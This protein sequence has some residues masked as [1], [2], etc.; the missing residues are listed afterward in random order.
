MATAALVSV[1]EYLSTVYEPEC[2][3]VDGVLEERNVGEQDHG[4]LTG[5]FMVLLYP[6]ERKLGVRAI[7]EVRL[8][9][10]PSRFRVPDLSVVVGPKRAEQVFT[11]APFLCIEILSPEDRMSQMQRK[12]DDY[13]E[14]GVSYV[15]VVDP[16]SRKGWVYT[17]QGACE[18]KDGVLRTANPDIAVPLAEIFAEM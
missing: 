3:Y 16:Q 18:A 2:D 10:K 9:V 6:L 5:M 14:M 7:P 4:R 1:E 17:S 8:R 11:K 12:I 13:L 15:W